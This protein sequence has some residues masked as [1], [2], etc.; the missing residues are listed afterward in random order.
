[1]GET[2][3]V[4]NH[5]GIK[6]AVVVNI[7]EEALYS[8][9]FDD[10]SFCDSVNPSTVSF[11]EPRMADLVEGSSDITSVLNAPVTVIWEG[12]LCS[13]VFKEKNILYWYKVRPKRQKA[14]IELDRSDIQKINV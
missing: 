13:G 12:E 10:G 5:P 4:F 9:A 8:I 3:S 7:D 11:N 1:M 2:V 14:I 6:T